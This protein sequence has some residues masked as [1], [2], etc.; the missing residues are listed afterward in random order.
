MARRPIFVGPIPHYRSAW[1]N[2]RSLSVA[3][4][5]RSQNSE[6]LKSVS[7][8]AIIAMT[9]RVV[10]SSTARMI[11]VVFQGEAE[12]PPIILIQTSLPRSPI[13]R[14]AGGLHPFA[15]STRQR[16]PNARA[17]RLRSRDR[18]LQKPDRGIQ[19]RREWRAGHR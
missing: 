19:S 8:V 11:A 2:E 12:V 15:F 5:G 7:S 16:G 4:G 10:T 9:T 18:R 17:A 13:I 1:A 3:Y 14:S 6:K